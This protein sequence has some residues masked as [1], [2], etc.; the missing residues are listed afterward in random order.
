MVNVVAGIY[1]CSIVVVVVF[2]TLTDPLRIQPWSHC[3]I[4][5][6]IYIS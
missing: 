3:I 4:I 5:I 6:L 1:T 2:L